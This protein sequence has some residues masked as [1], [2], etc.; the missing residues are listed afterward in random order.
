M[1]EQKK[2]YGSVFFPDCDLPLSPSRGARRGTSPTRAS[3]G[4]NPASSW[5]PRRCWPRRGCFLQTARRRRRAS[6]LRARRL[7]PS[8]PPSRRALAST[9]ASNCDPWRSLMGCRKWEST[10]RAEHR[11]VSLSGEANESALGGRFFR[12]TTDGSHFFSFFLSSLSP[13]LRRNAERSRDG[14]KRKKKLFLFFHFFTK[15]RACLRP[16]P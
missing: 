11:A 9:S 4:G 16:S 10:G 14:K 8:Q 6:T 15:Q 12:S 3:S 5:D 13:R 2:N 1:H 7:P